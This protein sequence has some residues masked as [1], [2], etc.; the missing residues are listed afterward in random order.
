MLFNG[1]KNADV[2]STR[3]HKEGKV[4][5]VL[6]MLITEQSGTGN[7]NLLPTGDLFRIFMNLKD[8]Q[9]KER[10]LNLGVQDLESDHLI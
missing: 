1:M 3:K 8:K 2:L 7:W 6:I 5:E 4:K 9:D 10:V